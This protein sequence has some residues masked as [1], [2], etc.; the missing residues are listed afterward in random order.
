MIAAHRPLIDLYFNATLNKEFTDKRKFYDGDFGRVYASYDPDDEMMHLVYTIAGA[1][2][3]LFSLATPRPNRA[4]LAL[5]WVLMNGEKYPD[6]ENQTFFRWIIM[7]VI[8]AALIT[9]FRVYGVCGM[10]LSGEER[11]KFFGILSDCGITGIFE[12]HLPQDFW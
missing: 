6:L 12:T 9:D 11:P 1:S 2:P 7:H 5:V 10:L 3:T 4:F 8:A